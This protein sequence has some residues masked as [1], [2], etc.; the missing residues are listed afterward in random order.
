MVRWRP[1]LAF[2]PLG[3]ALAVAA[4]GGSGTSGYSSPPATT[5][6]ATTAT[7]TARSAPPATA[8]SKPK[9]HASPPGALQAEA[10]SAAAGDIPD[11]Q[12]FL[13]F[14]NG[15]GRLLDEVP[16]GVG[17]ARLR[18]ARSS[19]RD[20]NNIVRVVVGTGAAPTN[21]TVR[22]RAARLTGAH[23]A[24]GPQRDRRLRQAPALKV[25][26]TH[27]ERAERRSPASA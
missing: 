3:A 6:P 9:Q 4:C 10:N 19:F 15:R 11:N 21:A 20:K 5:A 1:F 23:V 18:Q 22:A 16:G 12:V 24:G 14:R 17:A 2:A 7:A 25:V 13:V 26:Y 27:R 8:S